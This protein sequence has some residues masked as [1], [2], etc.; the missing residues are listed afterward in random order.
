MGHSLKLLADHNINGP[1]VSYALNAL[2]LA[3]KDVGRLDE[4]E[5]TC[6]PARYISYKAIH[7]FDGDRVDDPPQGHDGV[8]GSGAGK[9]SPHGH[10][11]F[12]VKLIA[13]RGITSSQTYEIGAAQIEQVRLGCHEDVIFRRRRDLSA[14]PEIES[15]LDTAQGETPAIHRISERVGI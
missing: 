7:H 11:P 4:A 5:E 3:Y 12:A 8:V 10:D 14:L 9:S 13:S 6:V 15:V 1:R 2:A